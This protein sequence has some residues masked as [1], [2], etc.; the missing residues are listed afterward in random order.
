[1]AGEKL[2]QIDCVEYLGV[3]FDDRFKWNKYLEYI[4]TQIIWSNW[5]LV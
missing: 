4:E 1:M 2:K 3:Y 5:C